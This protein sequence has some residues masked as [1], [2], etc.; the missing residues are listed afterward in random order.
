M[1]GE[2]TSLTFAM[3]PLDYFLLQFFQLCEQGLAGHELM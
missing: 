3:Q 1:P 2:N